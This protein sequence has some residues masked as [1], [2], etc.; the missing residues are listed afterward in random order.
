MANDFST[1]LQKLENLA[2]AN[3]NSISSLDVMN[4]IEEQDGDPDLVDKLF[5]ELEAKGIAIVA[6]TSVE[7]DAIREM[8]LE[9]DNVRTEYESSL[10]GGK[11]AYNFVLKS[12]Q[13][14]NHDILFQS[15]RD[16]PGVSYVE[17]L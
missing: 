12:K 15:I 7:D 3:N 9:I 10:E 14:I 4:I 6:E 8:N 2:N 16:I 5:D 11:H 13:K 1:I 17:G